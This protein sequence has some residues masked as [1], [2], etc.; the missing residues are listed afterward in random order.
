MLCKYSDIFCDPMSESGVRF[1]IVVIALNG[2]ATVSQYGNTLEADILG[3]C[4]LFIAFLCGLEIDLI[5]ISHFA[6]PIACL[7]GMEPG[8][9]VRNTII[10][11][12]PWLP[13]N[14]STWYR[15]C[16]GLTHQAIKQG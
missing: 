12:H 8:V 10:S 6:R 13:L 4:L 3:L 14:N 1:N 15:A 5:S 2:V 16:C 7:C 9:I 11:S